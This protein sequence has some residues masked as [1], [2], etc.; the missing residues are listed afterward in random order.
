MEQMIAQASPREYPALE[1][2]ILYSIRI[3]ERDRLS[4]LVISMDSAW[5][6]H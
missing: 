4:C 5:G 1:N 6:L 3:P 2:V